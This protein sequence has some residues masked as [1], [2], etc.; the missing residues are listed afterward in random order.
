VASLISL[1][2]IEGRTDSSQFHL[3]AGRGALVLMRARPNRSISF[4]RRTVVGTQDSA[5]HNS[6]NRSSM[7]A[8]SGPT[9]AL[10]PFVDRRRHSHAHRAPIL[11]PVNKAFSCSSGNSK[12]SH[13]GDMLPSSL[14]PR[15][16][17]RVESAAYVGVSPSH[18]DVMVKDRRMPAP[19]KVNSRSIWDRIKLDRAFEALPDR[20]DESVNPFD[21]VT[22]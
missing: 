17:S 6:I 1:I 15:G 9:P 2:A 11:H 10:Q 20:D 19:K 3:A 21:E 16:L 14:P 12:M 8:S 4:L 22:A 5:G 7:I 18:F 13:R